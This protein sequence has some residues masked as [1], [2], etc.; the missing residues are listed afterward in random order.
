MN[1]NEK[2]MFETLCRGERYIKTF[3]GRWVKAGQ[4]D[5]QS[6][7]VSYFPFCLNQVRKYD[8]VSRWL[9]GLKSMTLRTDF[10][11]FLAGLS[12]C[13]QNKILFIPLVDIYF[14]RKSMIKLNWKRNA[15]W[16][17]LQ[18]L[19]LQGVER[20]TLSL[21]PFPKIVWEWMLATQRGEGD[22]WR[23]GAKNSTADLS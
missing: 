19:R 11:F 10:A 2:V 8:E 20:K 13:W 16:T 7:W 1:T 6:P 15:T 14:E 4:G 22:M 12:R 5:S 17:L 23:T 21:S 18:N 3:L 9:W